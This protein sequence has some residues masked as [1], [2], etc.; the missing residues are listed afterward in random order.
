MTDYAAGHAGIE[1]DFIDLSSAG[2][3]SLFQRDP[4]PSAPKPDKNKF[5]YKN[6]VKDLLTKILTNDSFYLFLSRFVM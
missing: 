5:N 4:I 3:H 1:L 2:K 6:F